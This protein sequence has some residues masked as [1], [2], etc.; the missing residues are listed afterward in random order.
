ML[1]AEVATIWTPPKRRL[2]CKTSLGFECIQFAEN[3]LNVELF[4]WQKWFLIHALELNP[5]GTFRF[6]TVVLLVG[7]QNGKSTLLQVLSLWRMY[8]D[9]APLILGT[10]QNLDVAEEQWSAAVE[11]AEENEELAAE[12]EKI[13]RTN[14]KFA[15]KLDS[16]QRYKV[17]AATRKGGRG[18][19]GDLIIM[20]EL[21]EHANWESWSAVTKTTMARRRAQT[22]GA[23]N[24]GDATSVVLRS[25]RNKCLDALLTGESGKEAMGIFEW[26]AVFWSENHDS[27]EKSAWKNKPTADRTGWAMA[28]PSVG[29]PGGVSWEALEAAYG[30][31][32]D[33]V[34][35]TEC[36]CQWVGS[37]KGGAFQDGLWDGLADPASEIQP[38][39][40]YMLGV[41]VSA[42]GTTATIS[43]A[44]LRADGLVHGEVIVSRTG[45][46]WVK[47]WFEAP[48]AAGRFDKRMNDPDLRGVAIQ[49][50][51][52][53]ASALIEPL[54]TAGVNVVPWGGA[55]LGIGTIQ[56][57]DLVRSKGL[58]H[59]N[60]EIL[61][62]AVAMAV[63]KPV[64]DTWYWDRRRSMVD[65]AGLV[66]LTA[67]AWALARPPEK[68]TPSAY[69]D[70]DLLFV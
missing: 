48:D 4:P 20:D 45:T 63:A 49:K 3:V 31:D 33:P 38:G 13:T 6:R 68:E 46:A 5:S 64:G 35:R 41:D 37:A 14:G 60:Q 24:A 26:S 59:L 51:G 36:L 61:T 1:G 54:E 7:R 32:P 42:D 25:L 50:T 62:T 18:M 16:G 2:T 55:D 29:H 28:N 65:I 34:F 17:A 44:G 43:V 70:D 19:S 12:I 40:G 53:P 21:R 58:R 30:S 66:A 67:A 10:A 9:G 69:D 56:F 8:V 15:L 47:E 22:I 52:A 23:S 39:T 27:P 57:Y 11:M